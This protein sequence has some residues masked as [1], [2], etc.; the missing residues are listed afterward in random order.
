M[1]AGCQ[2]S[3][4]GQIS[5][6]PPLFNALMAHLPGKDQLGLRLNNTLSFMFIEYT[7]SGADREPEIAKDL[8]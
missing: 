5:N 7:Q 8:L 2:L 3:F 6:L 4:F 1:G